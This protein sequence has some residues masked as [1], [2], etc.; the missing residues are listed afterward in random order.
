MWLCERD[1]VLVRVDM[2]VGRGVGVG[3]G[4]GVGTGVGVGL[5][6]ESGDFY[7]YQG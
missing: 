3:V 5:V 2:R 4:V 1:W 6:V 7:G